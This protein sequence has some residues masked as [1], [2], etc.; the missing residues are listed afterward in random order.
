MAADALAADENLGR[1]RDSVL[2]L[3][4][5]SLLAR[6]EVMILDLVAGALS[7]CRAFSP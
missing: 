4:G 5:V 2:G 6:G 3:E 1:G 7:R